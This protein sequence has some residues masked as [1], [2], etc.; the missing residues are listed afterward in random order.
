MP[1]IHAT[2]STQLDD[3]KRAN[4]TA[5]F[6]KVCVDALD[7]PADFVMTA[8]NDNTPMAFQNSTAPCAYIRVEVYGDYAPGAPAKVTPVITAA[9]TKEC[10]IPADRIYVLYYHT[11]HVGWSGQNF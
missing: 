11:P 3:T 6:K 4:L 2:L 8:F 1:F 9:V 10:G 5:A 7:K